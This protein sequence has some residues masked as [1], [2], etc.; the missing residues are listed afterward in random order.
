M[1]EMMKHDIDELQIAELFYL[2]TMHARR[3]RVQAVCVCHLLGQ[4]ITNVQDRRVAE[5][6][7]HRPLANFGLVDGDLR[8]Y[9]NIMLHMR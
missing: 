6:N 8:V 5:N 9:R 2:A 3:K 1:L 4:E 7:V